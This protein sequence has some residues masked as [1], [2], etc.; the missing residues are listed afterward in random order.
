MSSRLPLEDRIGHAIKHAGVAI[1][2]TT[3]TDFL[4]FGIG[5]RSHLPAFSSFCCYA[6]TGIIAVFLSISSFFL[7]WLILDQKRIEE[8]RD[9][10]ICCL[11]KNDGWIPNECSKKSFQEFI[12]HKYS[13]YLDKR[14]FKIT[15]LIVT[16]VMFVT[17]CIGVAM[18]ESNF[19]VVRWL[20]REIEYVHEYFDSESKY[21]PNDDIGG[22]IYVADI[23]LIEGKLKEI[24]EVIET[25]KTIPE[26]PGIHILSF[27]PFFFKYM[28]DTHEINDLQDVLDTRRGFRDFL[29]QTF[30]APDV[31]LWKRNIIFVDNLELDCDE[32]EITPPIQVLKFAYFHKR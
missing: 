19:D 16:A 31:F 25:L 22:H 26:L 11:K 18:L 30:E 10:I 14:S 3:L 2:I 13:T 17:S 8:K 29:C 32:M 9:A 6:A 20:P 28:K 4:A 12:F 1:T 27:L 23:P 15:A 21:F 24:H 5:A 7:A